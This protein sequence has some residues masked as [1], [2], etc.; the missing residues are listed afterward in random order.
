VLKG[1]SAAIYGV[2]G[3]NG[4]IAIYTR[5]GSDNLSSTLPREGIV[6]Y[7]ALGYYKA[8][9]FYSPDY[10]KT[11]PKTPKP[12]MRSTI[13]WNGQIKTDPLG[14][15]KIVFHT[16]DAPTRYRLVAEGLSLAGLP[17]ATVQYLEIKKE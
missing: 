17:G 6:N 11:P 3:A 2:Q 9:E 4:V 10:T 16:A 12:D 1:T 5:R 15:A 7:V 8:R 13:Y 14:R